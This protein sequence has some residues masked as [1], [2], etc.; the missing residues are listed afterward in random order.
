MKRMKLLAIFLVFLV[1][2]GIAICLG[3]VKAKGVPQKDRNIILQK[4]NNLRNLISQGKVSGQP[5]ATNMKIMVYSPILEKKAQEVA[6]TCEFK[7]VTIKGTPWSWVGQNLYIHM[8]TGDSPGADWDSAIQSWFDE[9]KLYKYGP[10]F[11]PGTGH[12]TQVV[13]AN[14]DNVGCGYTYFIKEGK[15]KYQKLYVCN[16]GPGGNIIGQNPYKT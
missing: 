3:G 15:F 5:K 14:T 16:Y 9:H 4:H 6:D 1:D 12:Y 8:S 7:H 13:W 2:S 11:T 10:T